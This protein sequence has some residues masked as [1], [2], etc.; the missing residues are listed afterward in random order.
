MAR[1]PVVI[2]LPITKGPPFESRPL[3]AII[4]NSN[5]WSNH[6]HDLLHILEQSLYTMT[7]GWDKIIKGKR[8]V[9]PLGGTPRS[10]TFSTNSLLDDSLMNLELKK[11]TDEEE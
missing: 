11:V 4:T 7:L 8:W 10:V 3:V 5:C 9:K 1:Q 2:A 6:I